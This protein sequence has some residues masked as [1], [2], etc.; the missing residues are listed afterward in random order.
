[1]TLDTEE[2]IQAILQPMLDVF[3]GDDGGAGF[4]RFKH[5]I[6]PQLNE[7]A[8]SSS[9]GSVRGHKMLDAI[10]EVS[11]LCSIALKGG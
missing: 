8:K 7:L 5:A 3:T 2:E 1:M 9:S 6:I 10:A 11:R 4:L